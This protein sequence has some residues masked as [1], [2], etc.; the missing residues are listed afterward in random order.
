M[1]AHRKEISAV[2]DEEMELR[3]RNH[4]LVVK[5]WLMRQANMEILYVNYNALMT[6]P[7][8]FCQRI[9]DFIHIPLDQARMLS[10]PSGQLYRNRVW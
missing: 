6:D 9:T 10:V 2:G 7:T 8:P 4:L 3:F 1:L 5:P